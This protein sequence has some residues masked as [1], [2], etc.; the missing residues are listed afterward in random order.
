MPVLIICKFAENPVKTEGAIMST[1]F[2]R[3]LRAGDP[4]V[5]GRMWLEFE[6]IRDSMTVQVYTCKFDDDT[7]KNEGAFVSTTFSPL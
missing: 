4:K 3:R 2:F 6:L 7:V 5:S 1:T